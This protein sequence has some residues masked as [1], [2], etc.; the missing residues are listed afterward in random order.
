[1]WAVVEINKKQYVV[2][3]GDQ[4]QTELLDAA[5][6]EITFDKVLLTADEADVKIGS[7]YIAGAKVKATIEREVKGDKVISFTYR[8][9][10]KS[11]WKKGHRQQFAI[12]KISEI[13][14]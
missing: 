10:K 11:R 14:A 1:M 13:S 12:L 5:S 2:N 7:P 3:K 4:I 6:G 9:R 8:R